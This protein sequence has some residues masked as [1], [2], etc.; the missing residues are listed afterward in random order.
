MEKGTK[1]VWVTLLNAGA[2]IPLLLD[3][4]VHIQMGEMQYL[5]ASV[6]TTEGDFM[7]CLGVNRFTTR[8][9]TIGSPELF[10]LLEEH[11][12]TEAFVVHRT[13]HVSQQIVLE[14]VLEA[15]ESSVEVVA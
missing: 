11:A 5:P 15:I 7:G 14:V 3:E 9:G 12:I 4:T 2:D 1:K 10:T 13:D 6:Y 8:P